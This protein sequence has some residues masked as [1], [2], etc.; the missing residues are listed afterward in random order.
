M[1]KEK[2]TLEDLISFKG[3]KVLVTGAASGIGRAI[4]QRFAEA[5]AVVTLLDTNP[6]G[7]SET[8]GC[9]EKG[10]C[11]HVTYKIDLSNKKEIDGF[12][13]KLKRDD[14]PDIL[15]NNAGIYPMENYLEVDEHFL[16]KIL[17]VN[18]NSVFW[19]CQHFIKLRNKKG[20]TIVNI[21]SI[22]A[23]LPF[24]KDMIHYGMSKAGVIALTRSLARDYGKDGFR[25][26]VILPGAIKTSGTQS[27]IKDAVL[28]V[29]FD[30]LK[31]GYDFQQRLACGRWGEADEVAKVVLFLSSDL[32]SYVQGAA[33]PVD[34]GFLSC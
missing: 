11:E 30:L 15:V 3:K 26:N 1:A 17:N 23:V 24:K 20:G 18:M 16:E 31:T 10:D 9:L 32:A 6:E 22:E 27:L 4:A 13:S 33:I 8:V 14:L 21:S 2:L 25:A 5:G 28:N 34:G 19:M 12:W 29:R 7:L